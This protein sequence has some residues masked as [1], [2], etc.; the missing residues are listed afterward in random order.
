MKKDPFAFS[1]PRLARVYEQA[2]R[3][4]LTPDRKIVI[5]SDLHMGNGGGGD[6][7]LSNGPMF[8]SVLR[9]HYHDEEYELILNGDVEELQ[10]FRL[11]AIRARWSQT[12]EIFDMFR[13]E[14]RLIRIV[15]N[16]DM[17]LWDMRT[18]LPDRLYEAV[19]LRYGDD[20]LLIFHGHQSRELYSKRNPWIDF[21]LRY[22]ANPLRI[23]NR[24]V[25]H[26]SRRKIKV[27]QRVYHFASLHKVLSVIGHTHRPMFESLS[28]LDSIKFE[29]EH[30]CR[31]YPDGRGSEQ[32][33]IASRINSLKEELATI[34]D[35]PDLNEPAESL[36]NA[37]L[38]VPCMFNSGCVIGKRGMTCL[39]IEGNIIRLVYWFDAL[40]SQK[41]LQYK[42]YVSEQLPGTDYYRVVIK[43]DTLDYIFARIRLL[44]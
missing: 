17:A 41:Y 20:D 43:E 19:R 2:D 31:S 35:D 13:T 40:R 28:K 44:T 3:M 27:E 33:E 18:H 1:L 5:F 8:N 9:D 15:G 25:S 32:D 34:C 38:V 16:H 6:D 22:V 29:I 39:E 4:E 12:F 30:L 11:S 21:T 14:S 42:R 37:N 36:Y 7:F 26:S 23:S 10:K 24:S